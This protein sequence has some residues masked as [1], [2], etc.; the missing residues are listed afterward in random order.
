MRMLP[1]S[2]IANS[3]VYQ[4]LVGKRYVMKKK[5]AAEACGT[6]SLTSHVLRVFRLNSQTWPLCNSKIHSMTSLLLQRKEDI[7]AQIDQ[8]FVVLKF[9]AVRDKTLV[10]C[11]S[12]L[13]LSYKWVIKF[14]PFFNIK[15][16][17]T[18]W[19]KYTQVSRRSKAL[20]RFGASSLALRLG[21][22]YVL[23]SYTVIV[24]YT[25][26]SNWPNGPV[27]ITVNIATS[28]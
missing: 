21:R 1:R 8:Q 5:V 20:T 22:L 16:V 11:K 3:K 2:S 10:C 13:G 28:S 25:K 7:A 14:Q 6:S 24:F 4:L 15:V 27:A 23:T 19:E 17:M 9:C 26:G 18:T 12:I